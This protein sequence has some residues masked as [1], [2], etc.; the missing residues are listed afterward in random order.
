MWAINVLCAVCRFTKCAVL[1]LYCKHTALHSH[2]KQCA[3]SD[4]GETCFVY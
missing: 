1:V 2:A 4:K 3:G